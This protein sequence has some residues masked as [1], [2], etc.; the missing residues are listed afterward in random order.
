M[1]A[2]R[3]DTEGESFLARWSRRKAAARPAPPEPTPAAAGQAP[4]LALPD[5][6]SLDAGADFAPFLRADVAPEIQ[7]RALRRLWALDPALSVPDGL[8]EYGEDFTDAAKASAVVRTAYRVGKG[9]VEAAADDP[10]P[11]DVGETPAREG[12]DPPPET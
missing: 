4:P 8:I 5:I 7:R 11:G 10:P 12:S 3:P 6:D 1:P 9:L 2:D